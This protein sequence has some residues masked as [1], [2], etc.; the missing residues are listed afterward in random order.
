MIIK[1]RLEEF[2]YR[3]LL[4]I[5]IINI[6]DKTNVNMPK[7]PNETNIK[8]II[9]GIFKMLFGRN[10]F[11]S[12]ERK[13]INDLKELKKDIKDVKTKLNAILGFFKKSS[14]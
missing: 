9:L 1:K 6:D 5:G 4:Y 7:M 3:N 12:L 2:S 8:I 10:M 13:D 11:K 14:I